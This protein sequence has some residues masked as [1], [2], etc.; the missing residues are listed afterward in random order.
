MP[1]R[2]CPTR[3]GQSHRPDQFPPLTN[4][5]VPVGTVV[6]LT[7]VTFAVKTVEEDEAMLVGLAASV[8][9]VPTAAGALDQLVTRL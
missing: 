3:V 8:I 1:R 6:P 4:T 5:M 9:L 7:G 2:W